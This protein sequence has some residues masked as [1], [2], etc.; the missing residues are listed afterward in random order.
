MGEATMD[1]YD[2]RVSDYVIRDSDLDGRWIGEVMHIRARVHYRN[3]GFP[4]RD[5]IDIATA[6]PYPHCLLDWPGPPAIHKATEEEIARYG[7]ADRSR[8]TTPR[9]FD[10]W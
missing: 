7:L 1:L 6:T 9:L 3:A 4:A 5:W 10:E 8:I 2:L